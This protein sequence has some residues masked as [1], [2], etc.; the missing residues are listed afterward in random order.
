MVDERISR[1]W[2]MVLLCLFISLVAVLTSWNLSGGL[3]CGVDRVLRGA[4][5]SHALWLTGIA[6]L[7]G[8]ILIPCVRRWRRALA[9]VLGV[10]AA[11]VGLAIGFLAADSATQVANTSCVSLLGGATPETL[12][13]AHVYYLYAVWGV[14]LVLLLYG[15][16]AVSSER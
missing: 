1:V 16:V 9:A 5:I 6:G 3:T 13:R 12:E 2:P 15:A 10:V 7:T 14:A 8:A 4:N 11:S